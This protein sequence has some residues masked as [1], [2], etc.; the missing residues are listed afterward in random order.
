M[1]VQRGRGGED[2][3]FKFTLYLS[4]QKKEEKECGGI[5]FFL[6]VFSVQYAHLA[7]EKRS[8]VCVAEE[9]IYHI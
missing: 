5:D 2:K 6:K 1:C 4:K 3:S 7:A 9:P 8:C